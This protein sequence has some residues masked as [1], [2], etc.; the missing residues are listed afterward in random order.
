VVDRLK[1]A[2]SISQGARSIRLDSAC[3][4]K[5]SCSINTTIQ[6]SLILLSVVFSTTQETRRLLGLQTMLHLHA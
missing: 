2:E 4:K 6:V 3:V 5:L 1:T